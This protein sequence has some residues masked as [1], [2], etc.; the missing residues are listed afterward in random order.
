MS[1][2]NIRRGLTLLELVVVLVIL[3]ALAGVLV[4]LLPSMIGRAHTA[5]HGTN[6]TEVNKA[7]Q[8]YEI[9]NKQYPDNLD[10]L[11]AWALLPHQSTETTT[12]CDGQLEA[13]TLPAGGKDS[14]NEAGV[15]TVWTLTGTDLVANPYGSTPAS[16]AL[17][18]AGP[19]AVLDSTSMQRLYNEPTTSTAQYVVFGLGPKSD[20]VGRPGGVA[21]APLHFSDEKSAGGDPNKTYARYGLVF[22][23]TDS[24]GTVLS[25]AQF[26][27]AVAFHADGVTNAND[28]AAEYHAQNP[29]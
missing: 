27:G 24:A 29:Q 7:V 28:A 10:Q 13:G 26:A 6:V 12:A 14:L 2:K 23:L 18:D 9:I 3:V 16:T 21:E 1:L 19:V 4:P 5:E 20:L 22:R 17:A 15:T 11:T 8:Q 25:K